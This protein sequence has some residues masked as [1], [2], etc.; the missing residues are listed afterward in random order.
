MN[1]TIV[2]E[3]LGT[4]GPLAFLRLLTPLLIAHG[5]QVRFIPVGPQNNE[6]LE[7]LSRE[8]GPAVA[9][10]HGLSEGPN[11]WLRKPWHYLIDVIA[12]NRGLRALGP[13]PDLLILSVCNPG[14]FLSKHYES[15]RTLYIMHSYA[16]GWRHK[17]MGP[18]FRAGLAPARQVKLV[19]VSAAA[20][21]WTTGVWGIK[22]A[23][24]GVLHNTAQWLP[25]QR[26]PAFEERTPL[27]LMVGSVSAVKDPF[28]WIEVA[29]E[30]LSN[31]DFDSVQFWWLG[32]GPLLED[33]RRRVVSLGLESSVHFPG[34]NMNVSEKMGKARAFLQLSEVESNSIAAIEALA[35]GV[36]AVVSDKGGLWEVVADGVTGFVVKKS[37]GYYASEALRKILFDQHQWGRMHAAARARYDRLF[38]RSTWE[39]QVMALINS[40]SDKKT[41][42]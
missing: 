34:A 26:I 19:T 21:D 5:H 32:A 42:S 11:T 8:F 2:A 28:F 6:D 4:G 33:C 38:S 27:V 3:T 15:N 1:I 40:D 36:P 20:R 24:V 14:R 39:Q 30:C 13:R 12:L 16:Q 25:T 22:K 10:V 7:T 37:S 29:R 35:F 9:H 18:V 31:P 41:D 23:D 17:I